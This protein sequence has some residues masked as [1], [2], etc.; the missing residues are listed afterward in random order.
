MLHAISL[1]F[2]VGAFDPFFAPAYR[3][4]SYHSKS[5]AEDCHENPSSSSSSLQR[6][7]HSSDTG[8]RRSSRP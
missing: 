3:C 6:P 4:L 8:E 7:A 1:L 2:P 5:V